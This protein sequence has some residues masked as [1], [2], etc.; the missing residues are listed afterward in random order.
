MTK[1][2]E[3]WSTVQH[4]PN[5]MESFLFI[6]Y[7]YPCFLR[8]LIDFEYQ[9]NLNVFANVLLEKNRKKLGI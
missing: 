6:M 1:K 7:F 9:T 3:R 4:G 5:F 8:F 2:K